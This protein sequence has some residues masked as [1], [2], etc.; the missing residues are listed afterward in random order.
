MIKETLHLN[1]LG[2]EIEVSH[3]GNKRIAEQSDKAY[4]NMLEWI[5]QGL[6][7]NKNSD[8]TPYGNFECEM[9]WKSKQNE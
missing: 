5:R 6:H 2:H 4:D 7:Q 9:S 3:E 1:V 8:W